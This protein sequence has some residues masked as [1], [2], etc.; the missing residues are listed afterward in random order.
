[1]LIGVRK[2]EIITFLFIYCIFPLKGLHFPSQGPPSMPNISNEW[3][4]WLNT[5]RLI[6]VP[7]PLHK[8]WQDLWN[9]RRA[10]M[11]SRDLLFCLNRVPNMWGTSLKLEG[12]WWA[13]RQQFINSYKYHPCEAQWL[14]CLHFKVIVAINLT[15]IISWNGWLYRRLL[16]TS[17]FIDFRVTSVLDHLF[18]LTD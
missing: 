2:Q 10:T 9:V 16:K 17:I 13:I 6:S 18:L 12:H 15:F 8:E 1:M 3:G 14:Y 11:L 4:S 7:C 5:N